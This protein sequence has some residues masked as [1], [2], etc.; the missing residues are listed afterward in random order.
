MDAGLREIAQTLARVA[1]TREPVA[2]TGSGLLGGARADAEAAREAARSA[3][4]AALAQ[5]LA[6]HRTRLLAL[7][8]R[9]ADDEDYAAGVPGAEAALR[10]RVGEG[11]AAVVG[12]LL[13]G[14]AA[15]LKADVLSGGLTMG[16]GALAGGLIGALGAAGAARGLNVLRGTDRSHVTWDEAA[17]QA[18]TTT[19]LQR[20]AVLFTGLP[21]AAVDAAMAQAVDEHRAA[22][23]RAWSLRGTSDEARDRTAAALHPPLDAAMLQALGQ[24]APAAG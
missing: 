15:G 23:A 9:A 12:G 10:G 18:I 14:A 5:E 8:G 6:D 2:D 20:W 4:L 16:A 7:L 13:S 11:R 24:P 17:M 21:P 19:L 1:T 3:L 22:L